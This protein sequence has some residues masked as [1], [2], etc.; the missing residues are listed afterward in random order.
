MEILNLL[1]NG[2]TKKDPMYKLLSTM[3]KKHLKKMITT[4][5][6]WS[7]EVTGIMMGVDVE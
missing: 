5:I 7:N 3:L 6:T 2:L 4:N 1:W